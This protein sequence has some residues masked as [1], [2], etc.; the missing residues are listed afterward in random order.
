MRNQITDLL[1]EVPY[2]PEEHYFG[3]KHIQYRPVRSDVMDIIEAQVA[4]N[5]GALTD[6]TSGVT[7]VTLHFKH[8]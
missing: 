8:E 6:F 1:R 2:N 7:T 5:T 3:P 4:E